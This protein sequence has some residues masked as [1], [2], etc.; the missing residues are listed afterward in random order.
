M[1]TSRFYYRFS[2]IIQPE[3]G[4]DN[5]YPYTDKEGFVWL[6][7]HLIGRG[8]LMDDTATT[9]ELFKRFWIKLKDANVMYIDVRH[10]AWERPDR[11]DPYDT[12]EVR[13]LANSILDIYVS[14]KDYYEPLISMYKA[15]MTDILGPVQTITSSTTE[16]RFNDTPQ[17]AQL[18]PS[19]Y[20]TDNYS[21]NIT[22]GKGDQTVSADNATVMARLKEIQDHLKNLYDDWAEEFCRLKV[23]D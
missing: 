10:P 2:D 18:T 16:S 19:Q 12:D 1:M 23:G 8:D 17:N 15:K 4:F 14:T 5:D 7:K 11:P 6:F 13:E 3:I 22:K 9:L 20:A 21:T